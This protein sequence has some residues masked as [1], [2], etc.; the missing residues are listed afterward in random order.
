MKTDDS[1]SQ[2][3]TT[4]YMLAATAVICICLAVYLRPLGT[5]QPAVLSHQSSAVVQSETAPLSPFA[6]LDLLLDSFF[7]RV[8]S[9]ALGIGALMHVLTSLSGL[10]KIRRWLVAV[11]LPTFAIIG[12]QQIESSLFGRPRIYFGA[13]EVFVYLSI[14][15]TYGFG[16]ASMLFAVLQKPESVLADS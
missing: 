9:C 8:T 6:V 5:N 3:V 2:N 11:L 13:V 12:W 1:E 4:R 7:C 10:G 15:F 16:I 14:V